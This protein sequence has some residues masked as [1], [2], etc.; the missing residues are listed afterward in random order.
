MPLPP[1]THS[2]GKRLSLSAIIRGLF[3]FFA[4]TA[5]S[6]TGPANLALAIL[7]ALFLAHWP[8]EWGW[9]RHDRAFQLMVSVF[10]ICALLALRAIWLFPAIADQQWTFAWA[11]SSPFL[12]VVTAW[13]LRRDPQL[14]WPLMAAGVTGLIF[15][16]V[17]KSDWSLTARVL[18]GMRYDFGHA[19]LGLAIITSVMLLGLLLMRA[20]ITGLVLWGRRRPL[21]GWALWIA[22]VSSLVVILVVTQSRGAALGLAIAGTLYGLALL[23]RSRTRVGLAKR[24]TRL[25]LVT[26]ALFI[27][28]AGALLWSTKDRQESDWQ[29][30]TVGSER[31]DLSYK[32]S[33]AIRLNL[34]AVGLEAFSERPLLGFGPGTSTTEF[35]VPNGLVQVSDYHRMHAPEFSH[36]HSVLVETLTRFGLL[37]LLIGALLIAVL[38]GA[39]RRL[40]SDP[41][42]PGDLRALLTLGG[43]MTLLYYLYDFR[44]VN[45]DLRFF[46]ILFLGIVYGLSIAEPE[47]PAAGGTN[48]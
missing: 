17:R 34:L 13:W 45:Q 2:L 44:L 19:A 38:L 25:A 18:E 6:I 43:V 15:G 30:L 35:L 27:V 46:L 33:V 36:L 40:W 1:V 41:R 48:G 5:W 3:L 28:L 16:A 21:L 47:E 20:R 32:G 7:C 14:V 39:Y 23:V 12:F 9:L 11:W 22:G 31:G 37:G 10:L 24:Q 4:F 8:A 26:A 42:I 29:E